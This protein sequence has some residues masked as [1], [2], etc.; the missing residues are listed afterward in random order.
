MGSGLVGLHTK[1]GQ[2]F[3]ISRKL[4]SPGRGSFSTV[5]KSPRGQRIKNT[6]NRG[7]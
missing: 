3:T 4:A 6:K 1:G 7:A 2:Q 5:S